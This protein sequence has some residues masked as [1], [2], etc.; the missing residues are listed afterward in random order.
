VVTVFD[1]FSVFTQAITFQLLETEAKF[2]PDRKGQARIPG[3]EYRVRNAGQ[4]GVVYGG[5]MEFDVM[6]TGPEWR[7]ALEKQGVAK[8]GTQTLTVPLRMV[9]GNATHGASLELRCV[10]E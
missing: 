6:L 7:A 10:M 1:A 5:K 9:V 8:T 4:Y 2:A 3:G